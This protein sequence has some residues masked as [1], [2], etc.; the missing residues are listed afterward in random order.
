MTNVSQN[1][2][3]GL[4]TP[5]PAHWRALGMDAFDHDLNFEGDNLLY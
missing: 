3:L 4:S 2:I 1:D 5:D